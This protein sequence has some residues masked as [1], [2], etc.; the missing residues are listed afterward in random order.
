MGSKRPLAAVSQ[1][2]MSA[3]GSPMRAVGHLWALLPV[4][5]RAISLRIAFYLAGL[6]CFGAERLVEYYAV[7]GIKPHLT[8]PIHVIL[9][10][11]G[12][13]FFFLACRS[14]VPRMFTRLL[15]SSHIVLA[16]GLL[17]TLLLAGRS[18]R[19]IAHIPGVLAQHNHGVYD[20][21]AM[22]GCGSDLFA[23]G[24][25]PYTDFYMV[26]CL[27]RYGLDGSAA[28]PLQAGAFAHTAGPTFASMRRVFAREVQ[29][30]QHWLPEF[31]SHFNYPAGSFILPL[32]FRPL[33][34]HDLSV[35]Y[36]V[37]ILLAYLLLVWI[38][39]GRMRP[40]IVLFALGNLTVWAYATGAAN[41]S[42][43]VL[44]ILVAWAT[45]RRSLLSAVLLGLAIATRQNAW[46]FVPFY[47]ILVGRVYGLRPLVWR[48]AI[49]AAVFALLNAPFA[50]QSPVD[51]IDGVLGPL[52]D[53]M[54]GLGGLFD[55]AEQGILPLLPRQG[56]TL[57]ELA[58]FAACAL[59]YVRVCRDQ[60]G[61][62]LALA[63]VPLLF[64]WRSPYM[65]VL[66]L[67]VL[68][69]WPLLDDMRKVASRGEGDT[70]NR[71]HRE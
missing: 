41:D 14:T 62:G 26:D 67:A 53:P 21:V 15:P 64:A 25:N 10:F 48:A 33:V 8:V 24:H 4:M 71:T 60:P 16:I 56:Y 5:D 38:A 32:L 28:T 17:A 29:Q 30:H 55:L 31:E 50:L 7:Q 45:W 69:L 59:Y 36:L 40:W 54:Y 12:V 47:A 11:I 68:A 70:I 37:C 34:G 42:L 1:R 65:Y 63:T 39:P 66:P 58:A 52:H 35:F 13:G 2:P 23:H 43:D 49:A 6:L 57:L 20:S 61:T 51:W 19:Q 44:L 18:L 46:F 27:P 3:P 22:T 9:P